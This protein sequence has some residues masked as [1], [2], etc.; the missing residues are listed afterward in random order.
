LLE[1]VIEWKEKNINDMDQDQIWCIFDVDDFYKNDGSNLLT[2]IKKA[3]SNKIKIVYCNECFE[4]WILLHFCNVP[5]YVSRKNLEKKIGEFFSKYGLG[6][7]RKNQKVFGILLPYQDQAIKNAKRILKYSYH[8][9]PWSRVLSQQGN[10]ST[11]IH[12]LI[13][14]IYKLY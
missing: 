2:L 11:N 14:E 5:A 12:F 6:K 13:E 9:I 3:L 10:P 4:L 8:I 1:Y 7:F